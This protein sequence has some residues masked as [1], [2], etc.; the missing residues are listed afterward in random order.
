MKKEYSIPTK[1]YLQLLRKVKDSNIENPGRPNVGTA[2]DAKDNKIYC[3]KVSID[4]N[5]FDQGNAFWGIEKSIYVKYTAD[6]S[7]V[8]FI[9]GKKPEKNT[10]IDPATI[11]FKKIINKVDSSNGAAMGRP[12]I[13][14]TEDAKGKKIYS[15][16]IPLPIDSAYDAG[17]AYW[18]VGDPLYV[19][20]T[21]DMK[22]IYFHREYYGP[23][24][25]ASFQY[26]E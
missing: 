18:G 10:K 2:D 5:G 20:F 7:Y 3:R 23:S 24:K 9:E 15:R 8:E 17:G 11:V 4:K 26:P 21:L 19:D 25:K 14:T 13:G 12:N 16:L 1:A 6:K 22:Y